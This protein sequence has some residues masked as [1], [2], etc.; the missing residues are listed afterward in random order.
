MAIIPSKEGVEEMSDTSV[1]LVVFLPMMKKKKK[2]KFQGGFWIKKF[3]KKC[4]GVFT[5]LIL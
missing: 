1:L 4:V 5:A 3:K 2:K